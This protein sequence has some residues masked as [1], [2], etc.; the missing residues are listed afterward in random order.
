MNILHGQKIVDN[1]MKR[2]NI[3]LSEYFKNLIANGRNKENYTPSM[4]IHD[5]SLSWFATSNSIK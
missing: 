3:T 5:H 1:K 4:H 2:K